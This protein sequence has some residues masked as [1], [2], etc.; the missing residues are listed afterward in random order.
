MTDVLDELRSRLAHAAQRLRE[1]AMEP[2]EALA[3][4]EE[5]ARL[6]GD[7]ATEVDSSVRAAIEPLPDF[8]G[9]LPLAATQA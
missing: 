3:V 7:A 1:D 8:P 4:I 6:A 5:C 9:Q 2:E